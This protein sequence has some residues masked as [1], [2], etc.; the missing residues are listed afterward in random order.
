M[1]LGDVTVVVL[2]APHGADDP[3]G[4]SEPDW[5][6]ATS[7]Q[8]PGCNV[9]PLS[10]TEVTVGRETLVSRWQLFAPP[11]TDLLAT[12][13]VQYDGATYEVDGEAQRWGTGARGYVTAVLRKGDA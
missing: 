3:Y 11:D 6:A 4:N 5:S 7:T 2:R 1:K 9:Q 10:V 8:V 13:R 12:D